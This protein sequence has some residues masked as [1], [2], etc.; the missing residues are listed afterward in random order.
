MTIFVE[1]IVKDGICLNVVGE[2]LGTV[3]A[4][5]VQDACL[6]LMQYLT[7]DDTA[8]VDTRFIGIAVADVLSKYLNV[9]RVHLGK[10]D[11]IGV[12]R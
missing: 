7:K 12:D 5:T 6:K 3:H 9:V 1:T 8:Y 2:K 10:T 11:M 4:D